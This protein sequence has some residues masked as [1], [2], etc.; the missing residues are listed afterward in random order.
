MIFLKIYRDKRNVKKPDTINT[1]KIYGLL[2]SSPK[3]L[4]NIFKMPMHPNGVKKKKTITNVNKE[5][6]TA[7]K[8][9]KLLVTIIMLFDLLFSR[10]RRFI[11]NKPPN[12]IV[13]ISN[14]AP[15]I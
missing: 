2:K 3:K 11:C 5:A 1:N 4:C 15:D 10:I 8:N 12:R 14:I 7:T 9:R 6:K 13:G